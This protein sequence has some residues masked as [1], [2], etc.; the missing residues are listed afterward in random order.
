MEF[1]LF[2][3]G[4]QSKSMAVTAAKRI[5]CYYE[6]QRE[7][8]KTKRVCYGTPG[9]KSFVGTL[10]VNP[11]R[12]AWPMGNFLYSVHGNT[13]YQ[14]NNAGAT[15]II[16]TLTTATGDVSLSDNN[17]QLALCD[18][19]NI[20]IYNTSTLVFTTKTG[21]VANVPS[22]PTTIT[23]LDQYFIV[24][25]ALTR[26]FWISALNDGTSWSATA[27]AVTESG[28][29]SLQ[30]VIADRSVIILFGD[31]YTEF[32]QD[33][34]SVDFPFARIPGSSQEFGLAAT[35]SLAK[36]GESICGLFRSRMGAVAVARI[37]GFGLEKL[38]DPD[39]DNI[40]NGYIR[41]GTPLSDAQGYAYVLDGHPMY[42]IGFPTAGTTWM[43]DGLTRIWSQ[44]QAT[45]GTRHWGA[46][47]ASFLN[48]Q[49]VVT[50]YRNGNIY[51]ID[52]DTFTDNGSSSPLEL[53]SRR[54]WDNNKWITIP[55]LEIFLETGVGTA[56]GQGEAPRI[57][58]SVSKDGGNTFGPER[59]LDMG[60]LGNFTA[61]ARTTRLGRAQDWVMKLRITDPVKRVLIGE[62]IEAEAGTT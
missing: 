28:S 59:F 24:H 15:S 60:A 48:N 25:Q 6:E 57:M 9:L 61:R 36:F 56:T 40:L 4:L 43:Y 21:G 31:F 18:G 22:N 38:S 7:K 53:W 11:S 62:R 16:G 29:G 1:P 52:P 14:I 20:Y 37:K 35:F 13:L 44:L 8:D 26:N 30:A 2:G 32:W 47:F 51:R 46:K 54:I 50:D 41:N 58:F 17:T 39:M 34:G 42:V 55:E 12:G 5:N 27:G 49:L 33:T 23:F 19:T 10:G 3:L 45:D